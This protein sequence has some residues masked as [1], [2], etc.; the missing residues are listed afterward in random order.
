[1]TM[2]MQEAKRKNRWHYLL[3]KVA[4]FMIMVVIGVL[5]VF[6]VSYNLEQSPLIYTNEPFPMP[7]ILAPGDEFVF[8]LE[9]CADYQVN[10]SWTEEYVG[11][12]DGKTYVQAGSFATAQPGCTSI[13]AV[14]KQVPSHVE[15][16]YYRIFFLVTAEGRF[17]DHEFTLRTEPFYITK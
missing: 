4:M 16:G 15:E 3:Y 5:I 6:F 8:T 2:N 10:Y 1:M 17:K 9:R 13:E 11:Q 7:E 12:G 14:P